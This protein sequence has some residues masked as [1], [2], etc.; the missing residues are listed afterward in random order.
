MLYLSIRRDRERARE[1][2]RK[3]ERWKEKEKILHYRQGERK[4]QIEKE[5][6][7]DD[8][9]RETETFKKYAEREEL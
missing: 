1:M 6:G 4:R 9:E 7:E 2:S 8:K 3:C 5:K